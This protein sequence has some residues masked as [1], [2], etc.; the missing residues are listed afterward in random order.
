MAYGINNQGEVVFIEDG[1]PMPQGV[2]AT[3]TPSMGGT[4][5]PSQ[6]DYQPRYMNNMR[7]G[8]SIEQML[9]VRPGQY[10][11]VGGQIKNKGLWERYTE[12]PL[13]LALTAAGVGIGLPA[14]LAA[15]AGGGGGAAGAGLLANTAA[16]GSSIYGGLAAAGFPGAASA[17]GIAGGAGAA[18]A[19]LPNT[20]GAGSAIN[21]GLAAYPGSTT[22]G[23]WSPTAAQGGLLKNART[24]YDVYGKA[25]SAYPGSAKKEDDQQSKLGAAAPWLAGAGGA[26][27]GY[28][29]A[30]RGGGKGSQYSS[31]MDALLAQQ[32]QQMQQEM[33]LRKLLL[34]QSAGLLPTYMKQDPNFA[35]WLRTSG[36]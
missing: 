15:G 1:A 21:S 8:G 2:H 11:T 29:L 10:A 24:A 3:W 5:T 27:A 14:L 30:N 35:Q 17:G 36:R 23:A 22:A 13:M 9:G 26:M 32:T 16:P 20:A 28:A 31:P 19:L 12:S 34:S 6:T 33:P 25:K 7:A 4:Y 18:G